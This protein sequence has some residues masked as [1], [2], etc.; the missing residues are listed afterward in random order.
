ME[1]RHLQTFVSV[2][3]KNGFTRASEHLGYAQS[4]VTTHI[5]ALEEELGQTLFE[6]LGKKNSYNQLWKAVTS[7]C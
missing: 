7:I 4:T 5:Q 3:E 6:R 1:I 2:V